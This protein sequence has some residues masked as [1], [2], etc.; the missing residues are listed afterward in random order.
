[1]P[2]SLHDPD[3]DSDQDHNH[4]NEVLFCQRRRKKQHYF[5]IVNDV[6]TFITTLLVSSFSICPPI[7]MC[8]FI[9]FNL[10]RAVLTHFI[11]LDSPSNVH[12]KGKCV[13]EA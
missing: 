13:K 1:M 7:I 5:I 11:R 12:V 3:Q 8:A 6:K 4:A 10:L 9:Q 2:S